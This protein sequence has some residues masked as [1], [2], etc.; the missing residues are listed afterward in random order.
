M[1]KREVVLYTRSR[2][3]KGWRAKRFLRSLGYPFDIVDTSRDPNMLVELSRAV[4]HNVSVPYFFIGER[5]VGDLGIVRRLAR[6]GQLEH[7]IRDHL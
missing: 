2:S 3:L 7:L 1:Y 4:R 6:A 5:P